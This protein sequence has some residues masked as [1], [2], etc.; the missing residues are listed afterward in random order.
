MSSCT[1]TMCVRTWSRPGERAQRV[2]AL[3]ALAP[4]L[5]LVPMWGCS[6]PPATPAPEGSNTSGH[7]RHLHWCSH[8]HMCAYM[9][10]NIF[11][12]NL[13][14]WSTFWVWLSYRRDFKMSLPKSPTICVC[15]YCLSATARTPCAV[16]ACGSVSGEKLPQYTVPPSA[17]DITCCPSPRDTRFAASSTEFHCLHPARASY[18]TQLATH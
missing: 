18:T 1:L 17:L 8:P 14:I 2:R 15:F 11:F 5:S 3:I 9:I 16:P 12:L 7:C 4:D 13:K 10:R 6:Q